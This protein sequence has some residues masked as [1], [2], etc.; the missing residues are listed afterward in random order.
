MLNDKVSK[1]TIITPVL[2]GARTIGDCIDSVAG[3]TVPAQHIIVDGES[4]DGTLDIVRQKSHRVCLISAPDDG[5]YDAINRGIALAEGEYIGI[6]NADDQYC[7]GEVLAHVLKALVTTGADSCYGDLRYVDRRD[8]RRI[9][10]HWS[11]ESYS[12]GSFLWG[13]MPPHPTF[14]M[15]RQLCEEY[16]GYRTDLGTAADYEFMLRLLH[17]AQIST[18]YLEE[19]LVEMKCG[20]KSNAT[21]LGR[22]QA[23]MMDRRAWKANGMRSL[24]WTLPL[25]VLRK[26]PQYVVPYGP[27]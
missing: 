11:A 19:T 6:L 8:N 3:Q 15:R 18:T 4:T 14:F 27:S 23:H 5:L 21:L 26:I 24:P 9:L 12:R 16:G 13:W 17:G 7:H 20:G 22:L 1:I 25:K 10:R 2:N